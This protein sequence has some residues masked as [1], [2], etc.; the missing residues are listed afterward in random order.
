MNAERV[1]A[2]FDVNRWNI[3]KTEKTTKKSITA[4]TSEIKET[5]SDAI[6]DRNVID[7]VI[8]EPAGG[9]HTDWQTTMELLANSVA[10]HITELQAIPVDELPS[11]RADKFLS[12]TRDVEIYQP[13]HIGEEH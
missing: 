7:E 2:V 13:E 10:K 6:R 5:I 8:P 12:M 11:R 4:S 3:E 1:C 9:A